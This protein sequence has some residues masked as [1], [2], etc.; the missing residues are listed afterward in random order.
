MIPAPPRRII[1][2]V[3]PFLDDKLSLAA[4]FC[5]LPL[6]LYSATTIIMGVIVRFRKHWDVKCPPTRK[7]MV[8]GMLL[9]TVRGA[10]HVPIKKR[11]RLCIEVH[12][13]DDDDDDDEYKIVEPPL[14]GLPE[15]VE[16]LRPGDTVMLLLLKPG[17]HSEDD[18]ETTA[19]GD[20]EVG[21]G[22]VV[23]RKYDLDDV[24]EEALSI[25]GTSWETKLGRGSS[26]EVK[27]F[28]F[29]SE[30]ALQG[31]LRDM[32]R[33]RA[34]EKE[35]AAMRIQDFQKASRDK[36][37]IAGSS[38]LI[39]EDVNLLVEIVSATDLPAADFTSSD[40]YVVVWLG[41][42]EIHRTKRI[43]KT[44]DPIWP[45]HKG[46]LF[47]LSATAQEFFQSAG[48]T[49]I[50]KDYDA[51]GSNEV[52]GKVTLSHKELLDSKGERM[53]Y[54]LKELYGG[55]DPKKAVYPPKLNIRVRPASKK[56]FMF[57]KRLAAAKGKK[58]LGVYADA[59][60]VAPLSH[61]VNRLKRET[62]HGDRGI[63]VSV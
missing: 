32:N 57:I 58:Q 59:A 42:K 7:K 47:I 54:K 36:Q 4:S 33:L 18:D 11:R 17:R 25:H 31:F 44:T 34:L 3:L 51:L 30:Q 61:S 6:L 50:V 48:L 14:E 55:Y 38:S 21:G 9:P 1:L 26:V 56:D 41:K 63:M 62:K 39:D 49:F 43:S 46:S 13:R 28:Q 27:E 20:E 19:V 10:L 5:L 23:N 35:M 52:L 15:S 8:G 2:L 45:V 40:P 24:E 37:H 29:G 12:S 16:D 60:F 53:E 22:W